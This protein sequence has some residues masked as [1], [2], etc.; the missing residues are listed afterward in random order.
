VRHAELNNIIMLNNV[1]EILIT[2][3]SVLINFLNIDRVDLLL[4]YSGTFLITEHVVEEI[5]VNFPDQRDRL[6]NAIENEILVV[7]SVTHET[8]LVIY[9]E[10][11]KEGRL[12]SGE[13]SAIACAIFRKC[14][15]AIDDVRARKQANQQ[16][17]ML[18]IINTQDIIVKLIHD[19]VL[20]IEEAD[21]IKQVW[22]MKYK[23]TL[24]IKS[25]TEVIS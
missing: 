4:S 18:K 2:D 1:D 19:R 12:G 20:S 7:V 22:Q 9:N 24:K 8:E 15:L 5:T 11:I 25:F 16:S 21:E 6:N 23:F 10:L 3:T 14:S 17:A 13:C